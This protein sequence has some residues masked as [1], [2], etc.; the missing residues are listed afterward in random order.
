MSANR[1]RQPSGSAE[2]SRPP[3]PSGPAALS[4]ERQ[5]ARRSICGV[6]ADNRPCG[7]GISGMHRSYCC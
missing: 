7:G 1:P 3:R 2:S 4:L 6:R 5:K